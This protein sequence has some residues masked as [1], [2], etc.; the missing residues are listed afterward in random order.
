MPR[1]NAKPCQEEY[2]L[3]FDQGE[4]DMWSTPRKVRVRGY[5]KRAKAA[6]MLPELLYTSDDGGIVEISS[7]ALPGFVRRSPRSPKQRRS[8]CVPTHMAGYT[9]IK[10]RP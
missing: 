5:V 3:P 10:G 6:G 1:Q 7:D 8:G 4:S 9:Y 2:N